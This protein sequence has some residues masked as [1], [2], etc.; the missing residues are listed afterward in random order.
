MARK[1]VAEHH[2]LAV[3]GAGRVVVL[4]HYRTFQRQAG[5]HAFRARVSQHFSVH[6]YVSSGGSVTAYRARCHRS[7][8][9]ELELA[10]KQMLQTT[11]VHDQH[12]QVDPF[13]SDLQSPTPTTNRDECGSAPAISRTAR[14]HT[15]SV[16][17]AKNEATLDQVRHD[18]DALGAVQYFLG[19]TFVG[20][21]HNG[22]KNVHG[23]L[24]AVDR[25]F[26]SRAGKREGSNQTDQTHQQH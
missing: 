20:R 17:A 21:R 23:F 1:N 16:L 8:T 19:N 26:T 13:D 10:G 15:T 12:H 18:D 3:N 7:F 2:V 22:L 9:G 25:V 6:R 24:Q 14:S 4:L 11:I 5:E